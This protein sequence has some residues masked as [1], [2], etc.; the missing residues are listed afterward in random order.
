MSKPFVEH[1]WG[2]PKALGSHKVDGFEEAIEVFK[3]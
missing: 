1:L 2:N 3:P